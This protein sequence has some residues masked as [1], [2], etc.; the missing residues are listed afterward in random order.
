M[1]FFSITFLLTTSLHLLA[2]ALA[3]VELPHAAKAPEREEH[4]DAAENVGARE[5]R[6]R[7]ARA[8]RVHDGRAHKRSDD[9]A[10]KGQ[11]HE[12]RR[13]RRVDSLTIETSLSAWSEAAF[14]ASEGAGGEGAR[15]PASPS[16]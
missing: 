15:L 13:D 3:L 2:A 12:E 10:Q 16:R 7:G 9:I 4:A 5:R 14:G 8:E 11:R 6:V 1:T